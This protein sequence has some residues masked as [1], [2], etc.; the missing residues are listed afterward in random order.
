MK[1]ANNNV[2][3]FTVKSMTEQYQKLKAGARESW[4]PV[5][6]YGTIDKGVGSINRSNQ[7]SNSNNKTAPRVAKAAEGTTKRRDRNKCKDCGHF[8]GNRECGKE[9]KKC[10]PCNYCVSINV[11]EP[12]QSS[13]EEAKCNCKS[14]KWVWEDRHRISLNLR[15]Q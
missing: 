4:K 12:K 3:K 8:H 5:E 10:E 1:K 13:H 6:E 9:R 7:N 11:P 14:S 15:Q 2:N